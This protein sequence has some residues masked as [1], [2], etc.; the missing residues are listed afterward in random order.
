MARKLSP[1]ISRAAA[2]VA[3]FAIFINGCNFDNIISG[4]SGI[5]TAFAAFKIA[6]SVKAAGGLLAW[7]T[8]A[9]AAFTSLSAP[10]LLGAAAVGAL[11]AASVWLARNWDTLEQK[12]GVWGVIG[13]DIKAVIG[14]IANEIEYVVGV[15]DNELKYLSGLFGNE[16]A[17]IGGIIANEF[18]YVRGV[19]INEFKYVSGVIKNE[20]TYWSG[21]IGNET[22]YIK[23]KIAEAVK[24]MSD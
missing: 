1:T 13:G 17:Y 24:F 20:V 6:T 11:V 12:A 10:I 23:D 18:L 14:A 21:V 2:S 3:N 16:L 5:T 7:L 8:P 19:V 15:V 9:G 22:Q 4:V